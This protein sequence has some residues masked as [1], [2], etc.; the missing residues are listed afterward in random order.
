MNRKRR[1]RKRKSKFY[2]LIS[3]QSQVQT[4]KW[5]LKSNQLQCLSSKQA[6][7]LS[8]ASVSDNSVRIKQ[9]SNQ[10]LKK[11]KSRS[12]VVVWLTGQTMV[13]LMDSL[14]LAHAVTSIA[15]TIW[16]SSSRPTPCI[17]VIYRLQGLRVVRLR[18]L[19]DQV[20]WAMSSPSPLS[21]TYWAMEARASKCTML[22]SSLQVRGQTNDR[23]LRLVEA[24][25]P[26][27]SQICNTLGKASTL[28]SSRITRLSLSTTVVRALMHED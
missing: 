1:R 12:I 6:R 26:W 2:S 19:R 11:L 16:Q 4:V 17:V 8:I 27:I 20:R 5:S 21:I 28:M 15:M 18:S 9:K 22:V 13:A 10:G 24:S 7:I 3:R 25:R 23:T 14:S